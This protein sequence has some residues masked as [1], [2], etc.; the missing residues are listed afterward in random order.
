MKN[1]YLLGVDVGTSSIKVAIIDE[2]AQVLGLSSSSYRLI[3]PN[4]DYAQID[5][6]DMW[7][8]FLKCVRLLQDGKNIDL[9]RVAGIS[10]SSLCP[11]LAALGE[12]GEVLVDPIIYSDR[13]STK[14]AEFIRETVGADRLLKSLLTR[15]WRVLCPVLPCFGLKETFRRFMKRQSISAM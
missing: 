10:I 15:L 13:R 9:S 6:E 2:N 1:K 8:A 5:T 3:T 11:G 4:Q 14:E 7:R 12:N